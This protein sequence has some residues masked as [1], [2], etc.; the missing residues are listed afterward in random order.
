VLVLSG[1]GA[2]G[3]AQIGVLQVLERTGIVP[4]AIVGSSIGAILGGLYACGYTA[5]ELEALVYATDWEELLSLRQYERSDLFVDQRAE[6]DRSLLTLYFENFRPVLPLAASSGIRMTAFLQEL[7]GASPYGAADFDH[8]RC[9]FRAVA[10]DLVRGSPVL[11]R[12]GD[13]ALAMRASAVFPLRYTPVQWDTLLLV[14]GGLQA[15][16]PV[17]LA[18]R[19]FPNA[20]IVAVNT[21]A[22]L[23]TELE[24]PWA[25]ADQS[26]SLLMRTFV[27]ADR[28]AADVL[29]EP[30]LGQH[31]TLEF[32]G[33]AEL[34]AR[35]R[36][37]AEQAIRQLQARLQ[38]FW[39]S[40]AQVAVGAEIGGGYAPKVAAVHAIG[41]QRE[42]AEQCTL[43]QGMSL[44]Y[45]VGTLLSIGASGFYRCLSFRWQW[46][47]VGFVLQCQA[48]P[49]AEYS[50]VEVWGVPEPIA[51]FLGQQVSREG[52]VSSSPVVRRQL[53]WRLLRWLRRC[54][55]S[56]VRPVE[57]AVGDSCLQVWLQAERVQQITC[58]GLPATQCREIAELLHL[59]PGV[60]LQWAFFWQRWQQ[61]QRSGVF[62][63]LEVRM[64]KGD[65]GVHMRF[66]AEREPSERL[67]IGIRT[68]NEHYT[69][70]WLEAAYRRGLSQ[71]GEWQ[72]SVGVGPRDALG[73]LQLRVQRVFPEVWATMALRAYA[74]SQL[75]RVFA[76]RPTSS[77][78][79]T[80]VVGERRRQRYGL[81]V[82]VGFPFQPVDLLEGWLRY[83]RQRESATEQP[84][85][86]TLFLWGAQYAHDSRD[87]A[88]FPHRGQFMELKI[89]GT[90]PGLQG[91]V[92][93]VR[94]SLDYERVI[95]VGVGH[96]LWAAFRFGAGDATLPLPEFFSLGGMRSFLG[97]REEE[98]R[99]RQSVSTSIAYL[100]P[101]PVRLGMPTE[102]FVR[103]DVGGVWEIPQQI[104][105][106]SLRY[107]LGG[108]IVVETP[109]GLGAIAVGKPFE[110]RGE[111]PYVRVG[112]TVVAFQ[113]GKFLP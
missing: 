62:R 21:T 97:M 58:A 103:W 34:I 23:R 72:L 93:F 113:L 59:R 69:R 102:V 84:P 36:E 24:T 85:F 32:R 61:L 25:I 3:I 100:L 92:A 94:V 46:N 45:V 63:T 87:R 82:S 2:R 81:R 51:F 10:T 76:Q 104:R 68:D 98:Q 101:S 52:G 79:N 105:L 40:V 60:S 109:L 28:A 41:F 30:E 112:P 78:W 7:V 95:P 29:I 55:Y 80:E 26:I 74:Q 19:E 91:G 39:D 48:E 54:G 9:R 83:E 75:V 65:S 1:G 71:I 42:D 20:F 31:G 18:R 110:F 50:Q 86:N 6:E 13:I 70:L 5:E 16:L 89:E 108:G 88:E 44:P 57:W 17:R 111:A 15:N 56:F 22:P 106:T 99:G 35:G 77:G 107:S 64:W 53:E 4:D 27:E 66:V 11:L 38:R 14:D 73:V 43:L 8:L 49:Y 47:E 33:F 12:S 90:M 67:H 96:S 37:A